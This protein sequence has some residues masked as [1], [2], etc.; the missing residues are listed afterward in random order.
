MLL[1]CSQKR[2]P[3]W[4]RLLGCRCSARIR[5]RSSRCWQKTILRQSKTLPPNSS[6]PQQPQ[7][8]RP[9]KYALRISRVGAS[10]ST[11][12]EPHA[13]FPRTSTHLMH[14]HCSDRHT[15]TGC[16]TRAIV[17]AMSGPGIHICPQD[18]GSSRWFSKQV[19]GQRF[20]LSSANARRLG[21]SLAGAPPQVM[22]LFLQEGFEDCVKFLRQQ[23]LFQP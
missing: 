13:T 21:V 19:R 8:G 5:V 14:Y 10:C 17:S 4:T 15:R 3:D 9:R 11:V 7:H 1:P 6:F 16:C 22:A 23:S 20:Y 12:C 18:R 2:R